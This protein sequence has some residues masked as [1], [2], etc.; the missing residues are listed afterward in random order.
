MTSESIT[1][2]AYIKHHLQNLTFGKLPDGG[3]ALAQTPEEAKEMG[4]WAINLD[5]LGFSFLL[6]VLFLY[7]FSKVAKSATANVPV[8]AKILL[9]GLLILLITAY[10]AHSA[11]VMQ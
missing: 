5:T 9:N 11:L 6:G 10:A 3:W 7:F 2:S 4:F 8:A 1:S